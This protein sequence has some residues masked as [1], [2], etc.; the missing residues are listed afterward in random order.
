MPD[1]PEKTIAMAELPKNKKT[2]EAPKEAKETPSVIVPEK[3]TKEVDDAIEET[4]E[5]TAEGEAKVEGGNTE[6]P[7]ALKATAAPETKGLFAS[8]KEKSK[9][10]L[11]TMYEKIKN[12]EIVQNI[13]DRYQVWNNKRLK[14]R[15][16]KK[17]NDLKLETTAE[18]A[19]ITESAQSAEEAK[20]EA[21][22]A[23]VAIEAVGLALS[24]Q[25][26]AQQR[27]EIEQF[28]NDAEISREK[29]FNNEME[30]NHTETISK[31]FEAKIKEVRSRLDG[32]LEAKMEANN[33][34]LKDYENSQEFYAGK[35]EMCNN[36]IKEQN[37]N[38]EKLTASLA[39]IKK[40]EASKKL[41]EKNI[42]KCKEKIE[43]LKF[44][45]SEYEKY[46]NEVTAKA[47]KLNRANVDLQN[48][49]DKIMGVEKITWEKSGTKP[50]ASKILDGGEISLD[51]GGGKTMQLK[52]EIF[53]ITDSAGNTE[54]IPLNKAKDALIKQFQGLSA[55]EL[56]KGGVSEKF[57][58]RIQALEKTAK[59]EVT[60][61]KSFLA[62]DILSKWKKHVG[63]ESGLRHL[64]TIAGESPD[65]NLIDAAGVKKFIE[66]KIRAGAPKST[67]NGIPR[68]IAKQLD[69]FIKK[70]K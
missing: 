2:K 69:E 17:I 20:N 27:E 3:T 66:D 41:L 48:K 12:T 32:R 15:A 38:I 56:K 45:L 5:T 60:K 65:Q 11:Q 10:F 34:L 26:E 22:K 9:N 13:T 50:V 40:S 57:F 47:D 24:A 14:E 68:L 21:A 4:A 49:R 30:A 43:R 46:N 28:E 36:L 63:N 33:D 59:P 6:V 19:K 7:E 70:I 55:D 62:K 16:D 61:E 53:I 25:D 23:K 42:V 35:I 67:E 58:A 18:E 31:E 1:S 54:E 52:G 37:G 39:T 51:Y 44:T 64:A 29:I 8:L